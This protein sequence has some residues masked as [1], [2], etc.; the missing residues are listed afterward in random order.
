MEETEMGLDKKAYKIGYEKLGVVFLGFLKKLYSTCQASP[1]DKIF[2]VSRDGYY[3]KIVYDLL[4]QHYTKLPESHYLL[5]SRVMIYSASLIDKE[6]ISYIANKDYFP[7]T[8]KHLLKVRFNFNETMFEKSQRF[9]SKS[10]FISFDD[11][12]I[13]EKN[14]SNFVSFVMFVKDM[15]ISENK[16]NKEIFT[17]YIQSL[18]INEKSLIV[19]IGYAGSLQKTLFTTTGQK[20]DGLYF[21][22]N[23]KINELKNY[24]LKYVSYIDNTSKLIPNFFKYV[25]LFELFFS[26][27]HPSVAGLEKEMNHFKPIFDSINFSEKTNKVLAFLHNGAVDF[28]DDY[29]AKHKDLFF[30]IDTFPSDLVLHNILNFFEKPSIEEAKL[31]DE[32]IFEDN[33]GANKYKLITND[34]EKLSLNNEVLS[35]QGIWASASKLLAF[36][37]VNQ[38]LNSSIKYTDR[39][40]KNF[41]LLPFYQNQTFDESQSKETIYP[42]FNIIINIQEEYVF[43]FIESLQKQ[44]YPWYKVICYFEKEISHQTQERLIYT[45][46]ISFKVGKYKKSNNF[47]F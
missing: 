10:G 14:H 44:F 47:R 2:F 21:I 35:T 6:S 20:I 13:Q 15:I 17:E 30:E 16:L 32:V 18:Q 42:I 36:H 11:L 8:L 34:I 24:G 9:L 23:E 45:E 43:N 4:R 46:N 38:P 29:L 39:I 40:D 22:V 33:F 5:S 41:E 25:Q 31:F 27:T 12:V 1:Y 7:T 37:H 26:A 28:V 3:L 19:D